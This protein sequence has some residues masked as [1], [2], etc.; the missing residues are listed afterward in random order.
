MYELTVDS[1]K[2]TEF[3]SSVAQRIDLNKPALTATDKLVEFVYS[4]LQNEFQQ[5]SPIDMKGE[6]EMI[7]AMG[8]QE[9]KVKIGT[10]QTITFEN[11]DH[12]AALDRDDFLSIRLYA[13]NDVGNIL[14]E[15]AFEHMLVIPLPLSNGG[16]VKI[17]ADTAAEGFQSIE[18]LVLRP[19]DKEAER[20]YTMSWSVQGNG[21]LTSTGE[22]N[23]SGYFFTALKLPTT[24]KQRVSVTAHFREPYD[25]KVQSAT[26][27]IIPGK[28]YEITH[29]SSGKTVIGGLGGVEMTL[30]VKDRYG[31]LV[32]D[33]TPIGVNATDMRIEGGLATV[34]GKITIRAIGDNSPGTKTLTVTAGD[35]QQS[36]PVTVEDVALVVEAPSDLAVGGG[37]D[38]TI[39]AESPYGDLT[40]LPIQVTSL[41]GVVEQSDVKIAA[42]NLV[43]VRLKAGDFEGAGKVIARINDKLYDKTFSVR[44]QGNALRVSNRLLVSSRIGAPA[45]AEGFSAETDVLVPGTVGETVSIDLRDYLKPNLLPMAFWGLQTPAIDGRFF[46][47]EFGRELIGSKIQVQSIG[48][49]KE[50]NFVVFSAP[51]NR[52]ALAYD[53]A[54]ARTDNVGLSLAF[55]ADP[56]AFGRGLVEFP[57]S[58]IKIELTPAGVVK[59]TVLM[60]NTTREITTAAIEPGTWHRL[61]VHVIDQNLIVQLDEHIQKVPLM[62]PLQGKQEQNALVIGNGFQGRLN[63]LGLFDWSQAPVLQLA[64]GGE[65]AAAT[66]GADGLARF[67]LISNFSNLMA[68]R[69]D[70]NKGI[71]FSISQVLVAHAVAADDTAACNPVPTDSL[72]GTAEAFL[73]FVVDCQLQKKIRQAEIKVRTASGVLETAV[74]YAELSTLKTLQTQLNVAGTSMIY[75]AQCVE[76]IVTGGTDSMA[77]TVCDF[78]A[79]LLLVGDIRDFVIHGYYFYTDNTEK[80]DQATYV[81]A[82]LGIVGTLAELTGAGVSVDAVLAGGKTA[83]KVMKGSKVLTNLVSYL[84]AKV[85]NGV[86]GARTAALKKV[87]PILQVVAFAAY[88]GGAIKDFL[89]QAVDSVDDFDIWVSYTYWMIEEG[90]I[91]AVTMTQSSTLDRYVAFFVG[92]AYAVGVDDILKNTSVAAFIKVLKEVEEKTKPFKSKNKVA[93]HFTQVIGFLVKERGGN[94]DELAK[95]SPD[96]MALIAVYA[97]TGTEG[98]A[99][100]RRTPCTPSDCFGGKTFSEFAQEFYNLELKFSK[101]VDPQNFSKVLEQI[102]A[103]AK[104]SYDQALIFVARGGAG[105]VRVASK[106]FT[107]E[108]DEILGFEIGLSEATQKAFGKRTYDVVV[109]RGGVDYFVEVKS[110][111]SHIALDRIKASLNFNLKK[112]GTDGAPGQLMKDLGT[113]L[114][115][116]GNKN[117]RWEFSDEG[118]GREALIKA[119]REEII[120]NDKYKIYLSQKMGGRDFNL[121]QAEVMGAVEAILKGVP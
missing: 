8:E 72:I 74:A 4:L 15:W 47:D 110:W 67:R 43:K 78:V 92:A 68:L 109:K 117:I 118:I 76:G 112:D 11:I 102:G 80:F 98:L 44:P 113:Y 7:L 40:G 85:L 17:T 81:F 62:A 45:G 114:G 115:S 48:S 59:V 33:G 107:R 18:G 25:L 54:F 73:K 38:V 77:S 51:D 50:S 34:N 91:S 32:A 79:S 70:P 56:A 10:N 94:L 88:E 23:T 101:G 99:A 26:Y 64:S 90:A 6:R 12:L 29:T 21:S 57:A 52:L 46:D 108:G 24:A 82:G 84:D 22:T 97:R 93:A 83:A 49:G 31:N 36:I 106:K 2:R 1:I 87:I 71:L 63:E 35:V 53:D 58:G 89:V 75:L 20:P 13:N 60:E 5:I 116:G 14:W 39:K 96:L 41:R 30:T 120:S 65:Q 9:A 69:E 16:T 55:N 61:G 28:P 66:V 86:S 3:D 19:E 95:K 105:T 103:F 37:G 119:V 27:E 104:D 121:I 100:L 42:G 111:N